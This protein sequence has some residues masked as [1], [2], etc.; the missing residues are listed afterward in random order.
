MD[1]TKRSH[2]STPATGPVKEKRRYAPWLAFALVVMTGVILGGTDE[3]SIVHMG[4]RVANEL[5][6][7]YRLIF[8]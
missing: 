3:N 2:M 5:H 8:S 4:L 6:Q 7:A 1:M